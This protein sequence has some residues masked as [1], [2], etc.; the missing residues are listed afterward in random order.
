[1]AA[2][3]AEELPSA[4]TAWAEIAPALSARP[5]ALFLDY[6]GTL[7]PIVSRPELAG[8]PQ[9]TRALLS[10]LAAHIPVAILSGRALADVSA[11]V[12]LPDLVYGG[13]HG[14]DLAGPPLQPGQPPLRREVGEGIPARIAAVGDELTRDLGGLPGVLV[15]PKRFAVA[16]HY[17]LAREADLP[18]IE[19][20]V[21]AALAKAPDLRKSAGKKVF[22]LRPA[23][24]WHKGAAL[25]WLLGLLPTPA[26]DRR[27][28][29]F[30]GDDITDEDAFVA[31]ADEGGLGILVAESPRPTAARY[32]LANPREV[33]A[34]LALLAGELPA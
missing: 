15:E 16:V 21:D 31:A 24:D 20:T 25:R 12:A 33:A 17:R 27:L 4:L 11:L 34:F 2:A 32:Q 10:R 29:L 13:S 23:I 5:P 18:R 22:E 7:T 3:G 30:I 1:L 8:L 9:S 28:P 26:G 14:F 6:D 19:A